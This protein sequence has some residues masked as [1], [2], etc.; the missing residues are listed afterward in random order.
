[1]I[2]TLRPIMIIKC[3]DSHYT[4]ASLVWAFPH[5]PYYSNSI[6]LYTTI[7]P[8]C[9][10]IVVSARAL[11]IKISLS[12]SPIPCTSMCVNSY[13]VTIIIIYVWLHFLGTIL[14]IS[15]IITFLW[16]AKAGQKRRKCFAFFSLVITKI[17]FAIILLIKWYLLFW[18]YRALKTILILL[19]LVTPLPSSVRRRW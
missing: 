7:L 10:Q 16:T 3:H 4:K 9:S 17:A 19:W 13:F 15:S 5:R 14:L 2:M 6:T 1:M 8:T 18:A 12:C 11:N